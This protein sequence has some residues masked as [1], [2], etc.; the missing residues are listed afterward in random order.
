M[1]AKCVNDVIADPECFQ[2]GVVGPVIFTVT[3]PA[4]ERQ[5]HTDDPKSDPGYITSL[6]AALVA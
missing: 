5:G 1:K 3:V 2:P 4:L 6:R